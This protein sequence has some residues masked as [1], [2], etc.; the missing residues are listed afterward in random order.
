MQQLWFL[1]FARP[2]ML[3][4]IHRKFNEDILKGFQVIECGHFF[5]FFF[6]FFFFS[7][8]FCD[9][10][11]SNENNSKSINARVMVIAL[12]MSSNVD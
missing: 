9:G 1:R 2:L 7:F 8:F 12:C 3:I 11:S 5:F 6:F 10:Q 4:D